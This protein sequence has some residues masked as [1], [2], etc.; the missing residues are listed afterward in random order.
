[1]ITPGYVTEMAAYTRW[2]NDTVYQICD[3][4]GPEERQ[5]KRGMFFGSIHHTL[6][7]ICKVNRTIFTFLDGK[8]PERTPSDQIVW[9]DWEDLKETRLMQDDALSTG[10]RDW[11]ESW[12]AERVTMQTAEPDDPPMPPRW[13][14]V[15]QI[16]NHQTHH[17]SQ[18]TSALHGM[19]IKYGNTDIP[20]RPG[21]GF[22]AG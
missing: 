11:I 1:M 18:V 10:G 22:F 14:M 19:G 12:L 15:T 6:D 8:M 2:Q 21:A 7:H 3:E 16:F 5:R 9:P 17:R 13:V 4:I 20:W